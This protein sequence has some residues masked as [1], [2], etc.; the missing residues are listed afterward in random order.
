MVGGA[1]QCIDV[2]VLER[3]MPGGRADHQ[4]RLRPGLVQV[5]RI[6]DRADHVVAPVHDHAGDVGD[7]VG[8]AQQLVVGIEE[9][10][11]DEVMVLDAR[12]SQRE[13][14]IAMTAR[15]IIRYAQVT[16]AAFPDCLLYTSDAADE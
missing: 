16:G 14:R 8:I 13:L 9:P 5:P 15:V 11:V 4:L 6:G 7:A 10:L 3:R 2:L 12:E 1:H